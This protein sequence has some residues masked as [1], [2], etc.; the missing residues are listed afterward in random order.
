MRE[1][2]ESSMNLDSNVDKLLNV[3]GLLV[4][5]LCVFT[6]GFFSG[7]V[8]GGFSQEEARIYEIVGNKTEPEVTEL[9]FNL[10]WD[11]W[12]TLSTKYVDKDLNQEG[13]Y[14]GA[15]KGMVAG[16][17]DPVTVFLTPEETEE[18]EQG[19][20]GKFEGVGIELGY[21]D[22]DLIV[23]VPL[24]GSPAKEAGIR[25][26]DRIIAVDEVNVTGKSIF[27]V[28]SLIR[29]E[30]DSEVVLT[31]IHRGDKESEDISVTRAEIT[32]PSINYEIKDG[33]IAVVDVDR[34]TEA[35][36]EA[37]KIRWK[38]VMD[39]VEADD[40]GVVILDMRGNP[41]GYFNAAV[42]AAGEFMDKGTLVA[43]QR[44]RNGQEYNFTVQRDGRFK[45]IELVV[46]VDEGSA[47][48]SEILAGALQH[49]KRAYLIGESTYGKG[50][51]Q[52]IIDFSDGSSLHITTLNWVLPSG[53]VLSREEVV[54]PDKKVEL[55]EEDFKNGEDPQM[56]EAIEYINSN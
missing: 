28:V 11:V 56:D 23:V 48:A 24:E 29:G 10:F 51:A 54:D 50:T 33:D 20:A 52:E 44:D 6:G 18:Y 31:V 36:L 12:N 1:E 13:L 53:K 25:A 55:D 39:K 45:D 37:W 17:G 47:S 21:E 32:V 16:V 43:K 8:W 42:W 19:N 9:D 26:G 40:P 22:G 15:I 35:S 49:H 41:G 2:S 38:E 34:F 3:I 27:E 4:V 30:K 7:K 14:Y 5:G 46:L